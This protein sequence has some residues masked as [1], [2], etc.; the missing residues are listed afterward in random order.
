MGVKMMEDTSMH[1]SN[2]QVGKEEE[3]HRMSY[4]PNVGNL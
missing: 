1:S 2:N 4:L 3:K